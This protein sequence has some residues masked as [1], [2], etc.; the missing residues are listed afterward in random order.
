VRSRR[1]HLKVSEL[2]G[3]DQRDQVPGHDLVAHDGGCC[4]RAEGLQ[5]VLEA[6]LDGVVG[7]GADA[8]GEVQ[9]LGAKLVLDLG[10]GP[11]AKR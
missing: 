3:A 9:V 2:D 11:A 5:P 7:G 4:L 6:L 1:S 10:L 8:S